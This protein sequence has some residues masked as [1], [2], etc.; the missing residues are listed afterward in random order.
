[1]TTIPDGR[2]EIDGRIY[3]DDGRGGFVPEELVKAQDKLQD[4]VVRRIVNFAIPLAEEV[5]RFRQHCFDDVD[6]LVALIEQEYGVK[7]GGTRG[8][9]SLISVDGLLKVNVQVADNVV[10][11]QQLQ[12]AKRLVDECLADWSEGSRPELKVVVNRAFQVDKEGQI[13]RGNLFYLLRWEIED[14][15]WQNAMRAIRDSMHVVGSK[16]YVR[17]YR[18]TAIDAAW[19]PIA[20]DMAAA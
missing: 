10:F 16:R 6:S 5:Q 13:N 12:A 2:R 4:E 3:W 7:R 11:G 19:T 8:N 20:I 15:R 17:M 1:M 18:R 9:I 14:E